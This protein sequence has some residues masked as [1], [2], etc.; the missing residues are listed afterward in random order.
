V[1]FNFE[2]ALVGF[3]PQRIVT[4]GTITFNAAVCTILM[5][6]AA[7]SLPAREPILEPFSFAPYIWR[8]VLLGSGCAV[9]MTF[10]GWWLKGVL[11]GPQHAPGAGL[12]IRFGPSATATKEKLKPGDKHP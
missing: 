5:A 9:L 4:E 8:T 3:T 1:I 6:L 10:V 7:Q 2:R 11:Y 12:H